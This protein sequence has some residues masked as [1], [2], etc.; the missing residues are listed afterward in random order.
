MGGAQ[1]KAIAKPT[2]AWEYPLQK[3]APP[4]SPVPRR[5]P[6]LSRPGPDA[7]GGDITAHLVA[8]REGGRAAFDA[9]FD[10]VY[11]RLRILARA[12][13]SSPQMRA[14]EL[15][16]EAYLKFVDSTRCDWN[17]RQ[18]FFAVAARAMRQIVVDH[19]RRRAAA[20]RGGG[21][22]LTTLDDHH[23]QVTVSADQV[24]AVDEALQKLG[25]TSPRL[26][27]VVDACF[28]LGMTTDETGEM[29]GMSARTVKREWQKARMLLGV[30]LGPPA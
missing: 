8:A 4:P 3:P 7:S 23:G 24:L 29:L 26:V 15:V 13:R 11:D 18:H 16:H 27:Q 6:T 5:V 1:R 9:L 20:R 30:L 17:D 10:L 12:Q 22:V 19:A 21:A 25:D 2:R 14:T 28:F